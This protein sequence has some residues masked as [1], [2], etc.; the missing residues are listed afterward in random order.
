MASRGPID[1]SLALASPARLFKPKEPQQEP[2]AEP[3]PRAQASV[4]E[5]RASPETAKESD[6]TPRPQAVAWRAAWSKANGPPQRPLIDLSLMARAPPP[7]I[8]SEGDSIVQRPVGPSVLW[9]ITHMTVQFARPPPPREG[10][11]RKPHKKSRA[12]PG[13]TGASGAKRS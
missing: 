11:E 7:P 3:A 13:I 12:P 8:E 5:A 2:S 1:W 4:V 9:P 10:P 6:R